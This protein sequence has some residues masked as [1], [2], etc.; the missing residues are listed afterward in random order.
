MEIYMTSNHHLILVEVKI[1][2]QK[3]HTKIK[4]KV[5]N[6]RFEHFKRMEV[7]EKFEVKFRNKFELLQEKDK[8]DYSV[9]ES[10]VF[11]QALLRVARETKDYWRK[12]K[13]SQRKLG[14]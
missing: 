11:K 6:S 13:G 4:K 8:I 9:E 5:G 1:I 10:D 3:N 14:I 12:Y 7:R 2:L